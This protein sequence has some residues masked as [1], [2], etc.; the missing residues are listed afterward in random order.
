ME[1]ADVSQLDPPYLL[2]EHRR[3]RLELA[4]RLGRTSLRETQ[5]SKR[6]RNQDGADSSRPALRGKEGEQFLRL[7]ELARFD[8]HVGENGRGECE[9]GREVAL[10]QDTERHPRGRVRLGK[11]AEPQVEQTEGAVDR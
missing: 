11:R 6:R 4:K 10:L 5:P 7:V 9:P 8:R 3:A 2:A 1:I